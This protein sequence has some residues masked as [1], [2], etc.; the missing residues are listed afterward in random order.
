[1]ENSHHLPR[2][3]WPEVVGEWLGIWTAPRDRYVPPPPVRKL[4]I[5]GVLVVLALG[6]IVIAAIGPIESGKEKGAA[7]RQRQEAA[8]L[9]RERAR[10][11]VDQAPHRG[12]SRPLPFGA[13]PAKLTAARN[14]LIGQ[15]ETAITADAR[16]RFRRHTLESPVT[17]TSCV[18]FVRP[19]VPNPPQPPLSA[20]EGKYECTG[21]TGQIR[22]GKDTIGA[23]VGYPFWARVDFRHSSWVYCKINRRA[24]EHGLFT[25]RAVVPL[26][27]ACDLFRG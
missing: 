19:S 16:N 3:S 10:L 26:A 5:G 24:G 12:R 14:A 11:R 25:E 23:T 2:A 7:A 9:A 1:V 20:R 22:G 8:V 17:A 18:P 13:S 27:P 21:V 4:V 15:L 6:A